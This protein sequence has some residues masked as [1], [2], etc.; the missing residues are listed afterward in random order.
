MNLPNTN[1]ESFPQGG[2]NAIGIAS[3]NF[4]EIERWHNPAETVASRRD[5]IA[6]GSK[7]RFKISSSNLKNDE[8]KTITTVTNNY[9]VTKLYIIARDVDG[10]NEQPEVKLGDTVETLTLTQD[11]QVQEITVNQ[12]FP[13][14]SI[15]VE[16]E[17]EADATAYLCDI[18][19]FGFYL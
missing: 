5:R 12:L 17:T 10:V 6:N 14:G 8:A 1:L 9:V 2:T 4:T 18:V 19:I 11:N 15:T 3:N 13:Q 7:F 16:V